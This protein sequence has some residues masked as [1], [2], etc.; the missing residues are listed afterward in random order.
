MLCRRCLYDQSP[1]KSRDAESPVRCPI[2]DISQVLPQFT[3][4]DELSMSC[5]TSLGEDTWKHTPSLLQTLSQVPFP[6]A[7]FVLHPFNVKSLS[8][9]TIR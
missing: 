6:S 8:C 7:D 1:V 3:V 5:V 9:M 2:D 4:Q